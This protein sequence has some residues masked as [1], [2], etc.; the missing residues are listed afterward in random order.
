[1]FLFRRGDEKE[2]VAWLVLRVRGNSPDKVPFEQK[3]ERSSPRRRLR[4]EELQLREQQGECF[5]CL[6]I[7]HFGGKI[8]RLREVI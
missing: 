6:Q 5:C 1:M 7:P 3:A 8:L 2:G 4:K